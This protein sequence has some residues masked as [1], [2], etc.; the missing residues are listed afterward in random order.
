MGEIPHQIRGFLNNF[1]TLKLK[2]PAYEHCPACSPKVIEAFTELGWEFVRK[3]LEDPLY[4]EEIS[5]LTLIKQEVE[6]LGNDVFE[7]EGDESDEIV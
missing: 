7:W 6:Q 1:S 2:T 3:A 4:L 5:G